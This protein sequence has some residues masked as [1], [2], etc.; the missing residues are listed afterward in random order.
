[1]ERLD[2]DSPLARARTQRPDERTKTRNNLLP[3]AC[4][5]GSL[6]PSRIARRAVEG[7][8]CRRNSTSDQNPFIREQERTRCAN[9]GWLAR[10]TAKSNPFREAERTRCGGRARPPPPPPQRRP[11]RTKC[12]ARGQRD[13][14]PARPGEKMRCGG[15]ARPAPALT[16]RV[17]DCG[18]VLSPEATQRPDVA[19]VFVDAVEKNGYP[20]A[21]ERKSFA[22]DG[23]SGTH[24]QAP[25]H[26]VVGGRTID[27]FSL[28]ELVDVPLVVVDCGAPYV[29]ADYILTP[30]DVEQDERK[31][32]P[33]PR[34]CLVAIR[35]GWG[36]HY[37]NRDRYYNVTDW[38]DIDESTGLARLHFPSVSEGAARLLRDRGVVGVGVD[39]MALDGPR[40]SGATRELLNR[41]CYVVANLHLPDE[42]PARGAQ[43]TVAPLLVQGAPEAPCRVYVR[44]P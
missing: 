31:H 39:T 17:I 41:D 3:V 4:A 29:D 15:G 1:M 6:T 18:F 11:E 33:I 2:V 26:Y 44:V 22:L 13:Q 35:T 9:R 23:G 19:P 38:T 37:D 16:G 24:V 30:E 25:A 40:V 7:V 34:G 32:G 27:R 12:F 14:A 5:N 20:G 36:V 8:T 43:M 42:L 10:R 28:D 21:V